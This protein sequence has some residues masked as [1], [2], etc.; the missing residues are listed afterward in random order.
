M[1]S[2]LTRATS[3]AEAGLETAKVNLGFT[4][5]DA[6][7]GVAK[8]RGGAIVNLLSSV[9]WVAV[10]SGGTYSASKAAAWALTN[11]LRTALREQGTQVMGVH[12]GPVDTDLARELTLPKVTPLDVVRQALSAVEAG[13]DEVLTDEMTR[14]SRLGCRIERASTSISIRSAP[15]SPRSEKLKQIDQ[16]ILNHETNDLLF[17]CT[18]RFLFG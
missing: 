10:P 2:F 14:R 7:G 15:C 6:G 18:A 12:A 5:D 16:E 13:R 1:R 3:A 17:R 11:W 8:H 4:R 9:S